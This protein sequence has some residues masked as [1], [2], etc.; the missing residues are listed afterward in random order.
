MDS[1]PEPPFEVLATHAYSKEGNSELG[2]A[3]G[4]LI[5]VQTCDGDWWY[6]TSRG[7]SGW[8]PA[9][10]VDMTSITKTAAGTG[11]VNEILAEATAQFDTVTDTSDTESIVSADNAE[12]SSTV[13][14]SIEV[15]KTPLPFVGIFSYIAREQD[16]LSFSSGDIV[17]INKKSSDGW[18]HGETKTL[19]DGEYVHRHG[20]LPSNYVR[21]VAQNENEVMPSNPHK[22]TKNMRTSSAQLLKALS[23]VF[24]VNQG[25][26]AP[27]KPSIFGKCFGFAA[28]K[29]NK[30]KH[31]MS[32]ISGPV[33]SS[34]IRHT[35]PNLNGVVTMSASSDGLTPGQQQQRLQQQQQQQDQHDQQNG[36]DRRHNLASTEMRT[37]MSDLISR[38]KQA[39]SDSSSE[40]DLKVGSATTEPE[41]EPTAAG[42]GAFVENKVKTPSQ[43][44]E[45][46]LV[47]FDWDD[48]IETNDPAKTLEAL[49]ELTTSR[50]SPTPRSPRSVQPRPRKS[51][52]LAQDEK[53]KQ[54]IVDTEDEGRLTMAIYDCQVDAADELGF[55]KG[56]LI[57]V[58]QE[59]DNAD[60]WQGYIDGKIEKQGLFPKNHVRDLFAEEQNLINKCGT[61]AEIDL[62][63]DPTMMD[64]VEQLAVVIKIAEDT[65][66]PAPRPCPS[67]RSVT[68]RSPAARVRP[69]KLAPVPPQHSPPTAAKRPVVPRRVASRKRPRIAPSRRKESRIDIPL[70]STT[71]EPTETMVDASD[72]A[73]VEPVLEEVVEPVVDE[74]IEEI[75]PTPEVE[76]NTI[77]TSEIA[78][79][80]RDTIHI[81]GAS[82]LLD[83]SEVDAYIAQ[84]VSNALTNQPV[85]RSHSSSS[86]NLSGSSS[87]TPSARNK[88][89][90]RPATALADYEGGSDAE[91]SFSKD[92]TILVTERF[93]NMT[94]MG[95]K[96][97]GPVGSFPADSVALKGKQGKMDRSEVL[98]VFSPGGNTVSRRM[99]PSSSSLVDSDNTYENI[100]ELCMTGADVPFP[101]SVSIS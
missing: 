94:W 59:D 1:I 92:D 31:R 11:E 90:P 44:T 28:K 26:P 85:P 17:V 22:L 80:F 75:E 43:K 36:R 35:Q 97:F 95:H 69:I 62:T 10:Y 20:W 70:A 78:I 86:S 52:T 74:I 4:D 5:K 25:K 2:F 87:V 33:T 89:A 37:S 41:P 64:A 45:D 98:K 14:G 19:E 57:R 16:E 27:K 61:Q 91:L 66:S 9:T 30:G 73:V 63:A 96:P 54:E 39:V 13:E 42:F 32:K 29:K 65:V 71:E 81:R 93:D 83:G 72:I 53:P 82:T 8:F 55:A 40:T 77:D 58:T 38:L 49:S 34:M 67:P 6:G 76:L 46:S 18:F 101:T 50:P 100:M 79:K 60:W 12:G 56:D 21:A 3:G 24:D 51:S 23:G 84:S 15:F 47:E 99:N 68:P 48:E 88:L 7:G